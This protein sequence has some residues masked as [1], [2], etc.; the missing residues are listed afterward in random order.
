MVGSVAP[1]L[2]RQWVDKRNFVGHHTSLMNIKSKIR[3]TTIIITSLA[4]IIA[5]N[6][7]LHARQTDKPTRSTWEGAYTKEQAKRGETLY[8]QHCSSCHG[9]DL[10]GNDEAAP[11][12]GA[13]FLANWDGLTVADLTE[14]VRVS[15]PP[16]NLGKLSRQQIVDILSYV[17]SF[18]N[19]PAGKTELDPKAELLKQIRIEATKPKSGSGF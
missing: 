12:T 9:P 15:M 14:R 2:V 8:A 7:K 18:N 19:F 1:G 11:L 3:S 5:L 10:S 17:L 13:A 16:N 6:S 4:V